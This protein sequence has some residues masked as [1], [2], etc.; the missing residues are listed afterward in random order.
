METASSTYRRIFVLGSGFSKSFCPQMPTLRDLNELIPFGISDEFPHLRDYCRRFLELCNNQS[1]YLNI[2]TLSTSILS[3]QIFPGMRESLYHSSLRFELLR[4]IASVIRHDQGIEGES[5]QILRM[6]L[7]NCVNSPRE[8][9]RDTL[10]LSFNYDMLVENAISDD[11]DLSEQVSVDYGVRIDPADRSAV[12]EPRTHTVDL[13]KLH[14][15]LNWYAVKGASDSLDLQNVCQ[16]EPCDRSFPIYREDTPIYIPMAHA[17]E[18]FLR[19]SLF[20]LLWSKADYYLKNAEEI[21][22]LGYGFPKTDMNN[23]EFLLAHRDRFK[24]VVVFEKPGH[25]E[26]ERLTG[27]FGDSLVQSMDA[28]IFLKEFC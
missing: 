21:Y 26:L 23:L 14:G 15:S 27:L 25:P 24:K 10:L 9:V 16:V 7:R 8:G 11:E 20:N 5:L 3:A 6:F 22:F 4:F 2:E 18:S 1:E 13:I 12:R 19:G 17:K 28:K